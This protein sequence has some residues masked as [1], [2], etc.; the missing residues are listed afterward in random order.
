MKDRLVRQLSG[1]AARDEN[2]Q[3]GRAYLKTMAK[4]ANKLHFD[5]VD[6]EALVSAWANIDWDAVAGELVRQA[7][8]K[9]NR[10]ARSNQA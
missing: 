9:T 8:S 4:G 6:W 5:M 1:H 7:A 3:Y 10:A 2:E